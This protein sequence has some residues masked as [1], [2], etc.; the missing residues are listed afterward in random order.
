MSSTLHNL[1]VYI[2]AEIGSNLKAFW[3]YIYWIRTTFML[4][5]PYPRENHPTKWDNFSD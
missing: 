2:Y 4:D 5:G 1:S 3:D